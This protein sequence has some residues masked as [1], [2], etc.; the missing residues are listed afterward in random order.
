MHL[1]RN[2][3]MHSGQNLHEVKINP[4]TLLLSCALLDLCTFLPVN[5]KVYHSFCLTIENPPLSYTASRNVQ[6]GTHV[7]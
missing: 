3:G 2:A 5:G 4:L 6:H 1:C 7:I